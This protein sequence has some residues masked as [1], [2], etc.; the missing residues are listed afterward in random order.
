LIGRFYLFVWM[1][2]RGLPQ[3]SQL[4]AITAA[5]FANQQ[6]N[7]K[8]DTLKKRQFVVKRFGLKATGLF[9]IW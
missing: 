3:K 1:L 5:P 9:T 8:A 7:T 4:L 6:M 2:V